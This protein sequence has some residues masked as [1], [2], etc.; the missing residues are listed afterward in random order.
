MTEE[1]EQELRERYQEAVSAM[2]NAGLDV[3]AAHTQAIAQILLEKGIF[4]EGE[5]TVELITVME[6]L[7]QS[8]K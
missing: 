2:Q 7:T 6:E 3:N 8:D 1:Q 5:Y 4:T